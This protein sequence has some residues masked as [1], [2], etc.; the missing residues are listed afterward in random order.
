MKHNKRRNTAFLFECLIREMTVASMNEDVGRAKE[1]NKLVKSYFSKN[2]VL[3]K[4][5]ELYEA[6]YE[7]KGI[8]LF[9]AEKLIH[10]VRVA[11]LELDKK[12][13]FEEQTKLIDIINK[14]FGKKVFTNFIPNYR[15]MAT[16]SQMFNEK[17]S[18]KNRV[19][20]ER[21]ILKTLVDT[22][23]EK[24]N[25]LEDIDNLVYEKFVEN[26]NEQYE[27][28]LQE[29][30]DLLKYHILSFTNDGV[31]FKLFVDNEINRV[32]KVLDECKDIHEI[33][34]DKVMSE[35]YKLAI[36]KVKQLMSEEISDGLIMNIMKL[37][38]LAHEVQS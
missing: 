16:I 11:H 4:E 13:V 21:N 24:N 17:T 26:Y 37:Q 6:L 27:E 36:D 20:L 15:Q 34:N 23:V 8:D 9:T 25:K 18:I 28:L 31:D 38:K 12:E 35:N 14:K 3:G 2:K 32:K 1:L 19:L 33:K 5:F 30:K 10:T 22:S 29:Q 7:T